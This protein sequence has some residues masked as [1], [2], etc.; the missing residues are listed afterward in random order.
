VF[1]Y[2]WGDS[3]GGGSLDAHVS[4]G[5]PVTVTFTFNGQALSGIYLLLGGVG[6]SGGVGIGA[7]ASTA[8]GEPCHQEGDGGHYDSFGQWIPTDTSDL[9]AETQSS[10]QGSCSEDGVCE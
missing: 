1:G 7:S 5:L 4:Y 8:P 10:S 9:D 3:P 2:Y 6:T